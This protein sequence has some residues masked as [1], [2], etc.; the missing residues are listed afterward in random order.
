[1]SLRYI[2]KLGAAAVAL[3]TCLVAAPA[4]RAADFNDDA[5]MIALSEP[6]SAPCHPSLHRCI[7]HSERYA[8]TPKGG[9]SAVYPKDQWFEPAS[10]SCHPALKACRS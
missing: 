10:A 3:A 4:I 1:M 8:A 6:V 5:R 9:T 7:K 2:V